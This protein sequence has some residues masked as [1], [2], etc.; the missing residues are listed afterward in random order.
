VDVDDRRTPDAELGAQIAAGR[1]ATI[2]VAGPDRILRRT[3]DPRDVLAEAEAMEHLRAA[4]YPVPQVF[5]VGPGEMVLARIDG[6][7]MLDDLEAHPW[8]IDRHARLLASL[9]TDLHRIAPFP[10]LRPHLLP[11]DAVLH[12]DLHPGNVI[13]SPD[14]PV[15][16]DW[17]NVRQ[18][19]AAADVAL[20]WILMASFELDEEPVTGSLPHRVFTRAE[21]AVM[22]RIRR[23][24]VRTF[25]RASG[26]E[27]QARAAL[28]GSAEH[29]LADRSVRPGERRAVEA[30]VAR[31]SR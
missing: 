17:T 5:R 14:G 16:I 24:L 22:P 19:E 20:T 4:G 18:G 8:R 11:G 9:H 28:T 27:D 6:P 31:E 15:V 23:R 26:I 21:R 30:L 29:R 12:Q 25:L 3:P 10:G 13:L 7:T 2:H 1:D